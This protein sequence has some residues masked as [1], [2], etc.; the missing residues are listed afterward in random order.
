MEPH[1]SRITESAYRPCPHRNQLQ[2]HSWRIYPIFETPYVF[3]MLLLTPNSNLTGLHLKPFG[4]VE[5]N[6][7]HHVHGVCPGCSASPLTAQLIPKQTR[8]DPG[9][10]Y[11]WSFR[12]GK[13]VEIGFF[14][15]FGAR[16]QR[17]VGFFAEQGGDPGSQ[18]GSWGDI[19]GSADA[20][21]TYL[22]TARLADSGT[23]TRIRQPS[24]R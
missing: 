24:S 4:P 9:S 23:G 21:E 11:G 15:D 10:E 5:P 6:Q 1:R 14:L 8:P 12:K 3:P 18:Q 17:A 2:L 7:G 19:G 20:Y 16:K 13:T 22:P